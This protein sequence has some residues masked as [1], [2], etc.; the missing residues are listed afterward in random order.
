MTQYFMLIVLVVRREWFDNLIMIEQF[1][2]VP[3][4][5]CQYQVGLLQYFERP[6][7]DVLQVA[8]GRRD[9]IKHSMKVW[10]SGSLED[11]K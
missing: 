3:G 8:Y 7:C 1:Q 4:I 6:E 10:K 9:E 11:W 2:R 5:F